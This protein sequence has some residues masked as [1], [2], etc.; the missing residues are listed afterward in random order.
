MAENTNPPEAVSVTVA[1]ASI[2]PKQAPKPEKEKENQK[3]SGA[4][5]LGAKPITLI[6]RIK[7][8][9]TF[10]AF[11]LSLPILASIIWLLYVGEY[12]CEYLLQLRKLQYGIV[13]GLIITFIL[14]SLALF[15]I[16]RSRFPMPGIFLLM[17]PFILMLIVGLALAGGM[18]AYKMES[19]SIPASPQW[20]KTKILLDNNSWNAIKSCIYDKKACQ[21]L[22]SRSYMMKS[23][24]FT[25]SKLSPIEVV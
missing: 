9:L 24:D 23:Y 17:I 8:L 21:S 15:F 10:I 6:L 13:I 3:M 4:L 19:Q 2:T 22:A 25:S 1:E 14:S 11:I 18:G 7:F 20:L 5:I 16:M 12:D